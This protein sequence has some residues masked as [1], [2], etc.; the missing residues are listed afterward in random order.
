MYE[1]ILHYIKVIRIIASKI[2]QNIL[3]LIHDTFNT[4]KV[5]RENSQYFVKPPLISPQN[6]AWG[7]PA[8]IPYWRQV[9]TQISEVLLIGCAVTEIC[10]NQSEVLPRS[11]YWRIVSMKFL[12]WHR[13]SGIILWGNQWWGHDMSV[14]FPSHT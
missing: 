12:Q 2:F 4:S 5:V 1:Y 9:T 6:D 3:L 13:C 14:V 7:T 11:G 8:E 10:F